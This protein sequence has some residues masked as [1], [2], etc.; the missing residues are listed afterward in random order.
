MKS[1][2][3]YSSDEDKNDAINIAVSRE[4]FILTIVAMM[5]LIITLLGIIAWM[6]GTKNSVGERTILH[7]V[8]QNYYGSV[9]K[10]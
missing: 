9:S 1:A 4:A 2:D 8:P 3:N 6:H 10:I 5:M 7:K